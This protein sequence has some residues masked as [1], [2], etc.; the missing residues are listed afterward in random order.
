V[1]LL[2]GKQSGAKVC[3]NERFVCTP[4]LETALAY[5]AIFQKPV[6]E[7]FGGLFRQIEQE[8]GTRAS[9]LASR[10]TRLKPNRQTTRKTEMLNGIAAG[11]LDKTIKGS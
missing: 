10:T 5:E 9:E 4:S 3:R 6:S 2:L 7:L 8:V 1:A 11:R